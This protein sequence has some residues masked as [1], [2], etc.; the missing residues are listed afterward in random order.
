MTVGSRVRFRCF[1]RT[2]ALLRVLRDELDAIFDKALDNPSW[3]PN[4]DDTKVIE[5]YH[6]FLQAEM[7]WS[8]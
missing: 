6:H 2:A 8:D 7:A 3:T 1:P 4:E 5:C